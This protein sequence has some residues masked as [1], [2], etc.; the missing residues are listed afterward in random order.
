VSLNLLSI[1]GRYY[2][3]IEVDGFKS[4]TLKRL[5]FGWFNKKQALSRCLQN[6]L[7]SRFYQL[8]PEV[9][10]EWQDMEW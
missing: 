10:T 7:I 5:I 6:V 8:F 3:D 2:T 4:Q 1:S 9:I